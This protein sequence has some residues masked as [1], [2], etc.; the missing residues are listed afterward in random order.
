MRQLVDI[1]YTRNDI[2]FDR[3]SFRARGDIIDI[4]PA[5]ADHA[6]R[7][8]LFGDE[9]ESLKKMNPVTDEITGL[10]SHVSVFPASHYVT[11]RENMERALV[12]IDEE[13]EERISWLRDRGKLLEAQRIE[14]RTRYDMEMLR[15]IGMCKGI[16]NYSRHINGLELEQHRILCSTSSRTII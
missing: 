6:I 1:Q 15:E 13:L 9:I 14:Q 3:G 10:R 2:D 7:V 8:E 16:E 12:T 11:S 4:Y 5:G